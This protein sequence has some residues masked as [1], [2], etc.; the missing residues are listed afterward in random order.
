MCD[1]I[2]GKTQ[3]D[4][5]RYVERILRPFEPKK[6]E[7]EKKIIKE[8]VWAETENKDKKFETDKNI[9]SQENLQGYIAEIREALS[10]A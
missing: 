10:G 8:I 7:E 6:P 5:E 3:I 2:E 4:Y 9:Y 1:V